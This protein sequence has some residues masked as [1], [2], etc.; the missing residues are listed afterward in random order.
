MQD[1][2]DAPMLP[3]I[4]ATVVVVIVVIVVPSDGYFGRI[5]RATMDINRAT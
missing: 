1:A 5:L 3:P 4:S 2:R